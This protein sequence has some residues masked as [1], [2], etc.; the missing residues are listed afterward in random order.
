MSDTLNPEQIAIANLAVQM[1]PKIELPNDWQTKD[2]I[3]LLKIVRQSTDVNEPILMKDGSVFP[4]RSSLEKSL[5]AFEV[6]ADEAV[7]RARIIMD[8]VR[9]EYRQ[10]RKSRHDTIQQLKATVIKENERNQRWEDTKAG[11]MTKFEKYLTDR[12]KTEL[13]TLEMLRV[14]FPNSEDHMRVLYWRDLMRTDDSSPGIAIVFEDEN[15]PSGTHEVIPDMLDMSWP[16]DGL[17]AL[18]GLAQRVRKHYEKHGAAIIKQWKRSHPNCV[19]GGEQT[20]KAKADQMKADA[21]KYGGDTVPDIADI[22]TSVPDAKL[23]KAAAKHLSTKQK[24]SKKAAIRGF[25][26]NLK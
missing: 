19:E 2:P 14:V 24:V 16:R 21:A 9:G 8:S 5:T 7:T 17:H 6:V 20:A 26:R 15:P 4:V 10:G 1:L 25:A 3:E 23:K 11:W 13:T 12:Q 22:V 18:A